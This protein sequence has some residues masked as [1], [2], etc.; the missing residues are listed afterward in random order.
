MPTPNINDILDRLKKQPV[1]QNR[2]P[3]ELAL[4][5]VVQMELFQDIFP[6]ESLPRHMNSIIR[7][8][9]LPTERKVLSA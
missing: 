3:R 9:K 5:V 7:E 6:D 4:H 2:T 8:Y 1:A